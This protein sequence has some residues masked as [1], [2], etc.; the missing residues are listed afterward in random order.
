MKKWSYALLVACFCMLGS[1]LNAQADAISQYFNQYLEDER[2]TVVYISPK[3]FQ[4]IQRMDVDWD[5][6]ENEAQAVM[7]T[8]E[9]LR[10]LRILI[11]DEDID[12]LYEEATKKIDTKGYEILMSVRSKKKSNVQVLVKDEAEGNIV[13]ELLMLVGGKESFVLMSFVG[14]INL[15]KVS[16][17]QNSFNE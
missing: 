16:E 2:F 13:N 11:A 12:T 8:V 17:L 15:K 4:M 14:K 10:G 5:L 7:A 9:D 3:M 6:E 1:M